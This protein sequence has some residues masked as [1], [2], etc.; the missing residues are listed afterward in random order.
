MNDE[1]KEWVEIIAW[2]LFPVVFFLALA[3][4]EYVQAMYV[5]AAIF[6]LVAL[7][8]VVRRAIITMQEMGP[9]VKAGK[10]IRNG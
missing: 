4:I 6:V 10:R 9:I 5:A 1:K 7:F 2:L 3:I 8:F